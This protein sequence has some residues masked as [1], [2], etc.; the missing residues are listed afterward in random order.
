MNIK[1]ASIFLS[2]IALFLIYF[3]FGL[4]KVIGQSP[5]GPM[6]QNLL[7]LTTPFMPF[8]L[9]IVLFGLFEMLIGVLFIIPGQERKALIVFFL[10]M[11][12]T[13][14]PLFMMSEVWTNIMV[15]TLEGQYIFKNIALVAC[16]ITIWAS[17]K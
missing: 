1:Q 4:L 15:P 2:R 12:T 8:G 7:S 10:H 14:L 6:V 16:A 5:A 9:F 3:W 17:K 13:A 11:I